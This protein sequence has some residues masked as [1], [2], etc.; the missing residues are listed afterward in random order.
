MT[1]ALV[2]VRHGD[3]LTYI[4]DQSFAGQWLRSLRTS[5]KSDEKA[6]T[7][8]SG[9]TDL[10]FHN[11][12]AADESDRTALS[13]EHSNMTESKQKPAA[14]DSSTKKA[15]RRQVVCQPEAPHHEGGQEDSCR[16]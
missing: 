3:M 16:L 8:K 4:H 14:D 6:V 1:R 13:P 10:K 11:K 12:A 15:A 7:G 5:T 9:E 2:V